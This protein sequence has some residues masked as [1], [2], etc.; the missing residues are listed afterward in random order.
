M[1]SHGGSPSPPVS[2]IDEPSAAQQFLQT[3]VFEL[4]AQPGLRSLPPGPERDFLTL[5]WGPIIYRT[6]YTPEADDLLPIFL[7]ALAHEI[8]KAL[9][10]CLPG[11]A[12]Q[13]VMLV[14]T[15]S[16]RLFSSQK[17]LQQASEGAVRNAFH[18]FKVALTLPSIVL[19]VRLRVCLVIDSWVLE[20]LAATLEH[21]E[22]KGEAPQY[23]LC[24]VKMVEENFPDLYQESTDVKLAQL[25]SLF[26]DLSQDTLLDV[27]VSSAGSVEATATIISEQLAAAPIKKRAVS[28][29]SVQTSLISHITTLGDQTLEP[30]RR[31][32][33][34]GQT[35]HLF[36]PHDVAV[37]TPCTIVH[38]FL[39]P[40]QANALLLELL[41]ESQ[42]FSRYKF[43]VFDKTVESPHSASVYVSTPE[44]HR[45]HTSV[46]TYGGTYRSNVR[47]I[48]PHMRSVS[49]KVQR[50]V[51]D[52]VQKRIRD[53]YP[54]GKKLR[55]QSPKEWMPNAAFVNCYDGPAESVGYHSDELTY[56][57]PKA[58]IGSLSLGVEREFRVRRIVPPDEEDTSNPPPES[59]T[60]VL[61]AGDGEN[62]NR[63]PRKQEASQTRADVQGQISIHL[64]HNSLLVMHA[65][66][67]EEWKHAITPA[68]TISPHPLSGNR[69]IN[70]TYRWYRDSLH[71]Q[72][73][74]RCQC[75]QHAI[76]RCVQRKRETR[77]R[78]MWTCY[79]GFAPGKQTCHFFQWA[80]FDDNGEPLW[81]RKPIEDDA[82]ALANFSDAT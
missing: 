26:P 50:T 54:D 33:K 80:E 75:G 37:H 24:P 29:P 68:Q 52:E 21:A 59:I 77:G 23:G 71:P 18:N 25:V 2:P 81:E 66:M 11:T 35:L 17:M 43:Q 72:Y 7:H 40:D 41:D 48:T 64:P 34:K 22:F 30:K 20:I 58:I 42:H 55:F 79:A 8:R 9:P 57:G 56:L 16:S 27:L 73:T 82:R 51:N 4:G 38:N 70:I 45:Q 60:D 5:T 47:Q 1:S 76:L 61:T 32:T 3:E 44:E 63:K 78:Y 13:H 74:P 49:A 31:P 69:R 6:I 15:Y 28:G 53:V 46:Y 14:N 10:R 67:Q 62:P 12:E 19:P 36:S 39:P 65:E